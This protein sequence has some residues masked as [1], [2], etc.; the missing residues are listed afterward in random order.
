MSK[1]IGANVHD[2]TLKKQSDVVIKKV[3]SM[4]ATVNLP[5]DEDHLEVG[6]I[7]ITVDGGS[8]FDVAATDS[9]ANAIL[10]ESITETGLAEVLLIGVV[11]EKYLTG[12]DATHKEHLFSNKIILR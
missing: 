6:Q 3:L 12:L 2:V 10:C 5:E 11:R 4:S 8:T 9:E 1:F 7:L